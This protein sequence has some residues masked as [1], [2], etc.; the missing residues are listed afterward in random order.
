MTRR[1]RAV[2]TRNRIARLAD[3]LPPPRDEAARNLLRA[4]LD[5]VT[6][7]PPRSEKKTTA[8][9][10][11]QRRLAAAATT[12]ATPGTAQASPGR[13]AP[14]APANPPAPA[15]P[16]TAP[17]C[18]PP[19]HFYSPIVNLAD[20][21]GQ[22][23]DVEGEVPIAGID[24]DRRA[25][26]DVWQAW[27]PHFDRWA[28]GSEAGERRYHANNANFGALS[29]CLLA[30][31]IGAIR[32]RRYLE[33]GS[34]FSSAVLLDVNEEWYA[35]D[36]IELT[37][38]DPYPARLESI[39]R[40]GDREACTIL[41]EKLQNV[42][43]D[44]FRQLEAGDVLFIDSSH[45]AKT[46][47]DVLHEL[48]EILPLLPPGVYVHFHDIGYP[49]DY[50]MTW[51]KQNRSWN[52]AYFLRAFLMYNPRFKIHFWTDFFARFGAGEVSAE[53]ISPLAGS[54]PT[55]IWITTV[56]A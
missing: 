55:S 8:S 16:D 12:T 25:H 35:D 6:G 15:A 43:L 19:G 29:A 45:V 39:L 48:F 7:R 54:R 31:A 23:S 21:V 26:A 40:P 38:I 32:P 24:L 22:G 27:R 1:G 47:S 42:D 41:A 3:L 51:L 2:R 36:P 18:F 11:R 56:D 17:L 28:A 4:A 10:Q 30:A 44:V 46:G 14:P 52:E 20:L 53:S 9:R 5:V 13:T 34:G 50:P 49:F 37:F 33:I